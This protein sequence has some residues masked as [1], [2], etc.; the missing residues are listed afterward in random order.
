MGEVKNMVERCLELFQLIEKEYPIDINLDEL[1]GV[2][3]IYAKLKEYKDKIQEYPKEIR[4]F[5]E[6]LLSIK[7]SREEIVTFLSYISRNPEAFATSKKETFS[8]KYNRIIEMAD[9]IGVP[10]SRLFRLVSGARLKGLL[11]KRGELLPE[12]GSLIKAYLE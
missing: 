12:Y 8:E 5:C 1:H 11:G 6:Y 2:T 7:C 9:K 10:G 4:S 3:G